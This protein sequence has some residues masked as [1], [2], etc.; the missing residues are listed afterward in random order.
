MHIDLLIENE[1]PYSAELAS[2]PKRFF[3]YVIEDR[4]RSEE[5]PVRS[6]KGRWNVTALVNPLWRSQHLNVCQDSCTSPS[7]KVPDDKASRQ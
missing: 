7:P 4:E 2:Q 1:H 5:P 3:Y 6:V